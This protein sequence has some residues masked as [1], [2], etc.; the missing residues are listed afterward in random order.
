M[1]SYSIAAFILFSNHCFANDYRSFLFIP[2]TQAKITIPDINVNDSFVE[3]TGRITGG[4]SGANPASV[5]RSQCAGIDDNRIGI[6]E[7]TA[8]LIVPKN[9]TYNGVNVKM[10]ILE[11]NGWRSPNQYID[12]FFSAKVYQT[13]ITGEELFRCWS[14]GTSLSPILIWQNASIKIQLPKQSL[15]PGRYSIP[16]DYYYAFEE[17]KFT[18]YAANAEDI[19]NKILGTSAAKGRFYININ[20]ISVCN[21]VNSQNKSINLSHGTMTTLEADGNKTQPYN[22][23]FKCNPNTSVSIKLSGGFPVPG[24]TKNFTKCGPGTCEL[25][26]NG[27]KYDEKISADKNGDLDISITSTFHLDNSNITGGEFI[28]SAVLTYLID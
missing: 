24:K 12:D 23:K 4:L 18:E 8:W 27:S 20:A 21:V 3:V 6:Q 26:F 16:V 14:V 9:V 5:I 15:Q 11:T 17:N 1:K 28:G 19:P 22:V 25:N 2:N 13:R 7:K 10:S